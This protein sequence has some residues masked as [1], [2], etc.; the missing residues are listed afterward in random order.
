[1]GFLL[2]VLYKEMWYLHHLRLINQ[3]F[4]T[5]MVSFHTLWW[6]LHYLDLSINSFIIHC[7]VFYF[8]FELNSFIIHYNYFLFLLWAW[9]YNN[10]KTILSWVASFRDNLTWRLRPSGDG[11]RHGARFL[12]HASAL[13]GCLHRFDA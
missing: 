6:Y 9:L 13:Y 3:T 10:L 2:L 1:M 4:H 5:L 11:G 7:N 8:Y 12:T